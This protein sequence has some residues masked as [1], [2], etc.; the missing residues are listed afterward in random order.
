MFFSLSSLS[1]RKDHFLQPAFLICS[2]SSLAPFAK[3]RL[4]RFPLLRGFCDMR[5][6]R[7]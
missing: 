2:Y 5:A 7:L 4:R 1:V 6:G 3:T